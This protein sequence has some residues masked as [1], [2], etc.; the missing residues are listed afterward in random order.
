MTE[1]EAIMIIQAIPKK[2][3]NQ[4]DKIEEEAIAMAVAAL[5]KQIPKK[6]ILS[7]WSP[8]RCPNCG[9]ELS[10]H[11]GDGYYKHLRHL[12]VCPNAECCQRLDWD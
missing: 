5:R 12:E 11:M 7:R 3:W 10:E 8:S 1:Q 9:T 2:I 6:V 4:M